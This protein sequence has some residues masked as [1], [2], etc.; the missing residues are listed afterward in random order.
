MTLKDGITLYHGS[1]TEIDSVDLSK[2]LRG[3]DFGKGFYL[4]TS[5]DQAVSFIKTS[6]LKAKGDKRILDSQNYGY[7]TEFKFTIKEDAACYEFDSVNI[8]WLYFICMNRRQSLSE[9]L[10]PNLK[11]DFDKYDIVVGKIANDDT[12]ATLDAFLSVTF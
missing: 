12:N 7:V 10:R 2:C 6:L 5:K 9:I 11:D 8:D 1:Y 4:T 3:K